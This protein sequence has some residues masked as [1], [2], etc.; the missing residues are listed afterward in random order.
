MAETWG[1]E[2]TTEMHVVF[3]VYGIAI[4]YGIAI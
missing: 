2:D 1:A 3:R 4:F